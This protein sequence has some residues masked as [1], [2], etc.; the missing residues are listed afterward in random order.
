M[1][2]G[3]PIK[4]QTLAYYYC[5]QFPKFKKA[6]LWKKLCSSETKWA[7]E[8]TI[9]L[10]SGSSKS[11]SEGV[12]E[13]HNYYQRLLKFHLHLPTRMN[14][15]RHLCQYIN[16]GDRTE[17]SDISKISYPIA[18]AGFQGDGFRIRLRWATTAWSICSH[19]DWLLGSV[20]TIRR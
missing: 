11:G 18:T 12:I 17:E 4:L 19:Q 16:A 1:P 20:I 10:A 5:Q 7:I 13:T 6:V 8:K 9:P 15:E 14:E 2:R 3:T